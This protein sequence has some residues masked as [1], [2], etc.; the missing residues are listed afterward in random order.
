MAKYRIVSKGNIVTIKS[1]LSFGEQI[2]EREINIFEQQ[3]FRGCFRP[4]QEGK[5]T[6][7]Y[8][9]PDVVPLISYLKKGVDEET[10]FLLA[11]Q[12]IEMTKKIEMNGLY[13]H[14]LMLQPEMVFVC[15]R[16]REVFFVYQPI[17]SRITSGNVYAFL[18]D[19]VQYAGRYGKEPEQFLKEFQV[20]LNDTKN[21]KIE[22][23]E[24]YIREKCPQ[25][26]RKI[27]KAETGK[28]GYIT[29]DRSSYERHY[30]RDDEDGTTLLMEDDE[31]GTTL[32]SQQEDDEAGTTLLQQ[33][34]RFPILERISTEESVTIRK[35][36]FTIGKES[37]NDFTILNNKAVS[38]RHAVIEK[39]NGTYYLMAKGST[40]H[41]Y[42]NGEMMDA[43][44]SYEL[45]DQDSIRI[46]DEEFTFYY[47]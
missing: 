17:N 7:I 44:R 35:N 47:N 41:T 34:E 46:A 10:F 42:L 22:D 31:G 1:K 40:N 3:I 12:T 36:I 15:E 6:I 43:E 4:R 9:A 38:R 33:E 8:T 11:A 30:H 39:I 14:N 28:S 13:L 20:F 21:Y 29:N 32:L 25:A 2:N 18:A 19:T 37:V 24:R 27:V 45:S 16:T 23:I 5:K 26:F